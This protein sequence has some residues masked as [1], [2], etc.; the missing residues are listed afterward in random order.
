MGKL[1]RFACIFVPMALTIGSLICLVFVFAGNLNKNSS[2]LSKLYFFR[3]DTSGFTSNPD[4]I[5][6]TNIDNAFLKAL[7]NTQASG[8]L[9]DFYDVGLW[10]YCSGNKSGSTYTITYCSSRQASF[11]FNPVSVWGLNTTSQ[12]DNA[13]P[14]KLNDG[15]KVYEKVAKF[16]F[17]C[18]IVAGCVTIA[19]IIVGIFAIFSRWGSMA[20]TIVSC[21][22]SILTLAASA[23]ATGMYATLAGVFD[24]VLKPYNIKASLGTSML[25]A[26][27]LAVAFSWAAGIFWLFST[28]CVSGKS[29]KRGRKAVTVEKTPYTYERVASP[30][31]GAQEHGH[32]GGSSY[33]GAYGGQTGVQLQNMPVHGGKQGAYEPFRHQ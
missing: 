27:W 15:L 19:E 1:G 17:A 24:T 13:I 25:V 3:A 5:A 20:T 11:W 10:N 21:A 2:T 12:V 6:G 22:S 16:M 14:Q 23:T 8:N 7:Q 18:Y 31:L 30:Y 33:G 9:Q 4:L 32:T 26:T 29:E 28:C